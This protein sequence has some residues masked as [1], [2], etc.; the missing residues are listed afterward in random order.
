MKTT[1]CSIAACLALGVPAAAQSAACSGTSLDELLACTRSAI[2]VLP[3]EKQ[4]RLDDPF[5][6]AAAKV[7]GRPA[8]PTRTAKTQYQ[9][10]GWQAARPLIE[11]GGADQLIQTARAK[12][13]PLRYGR[14]EALFAAG[15]RAAGFKQTDPAARSLAA[16]PATARQINTELLTLA[17]TA[18]EFEQGDLAHAAASLA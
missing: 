2:M 17:R 13:D 4:A 12:S 10:Y 18:G 14:A 6:I 11:Q 8:D 5:E 15:I 3:P 7:E 1:I 9:D 16:D